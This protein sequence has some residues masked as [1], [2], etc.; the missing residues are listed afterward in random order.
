MSGKT[1][2]VIAHR[3]RSIV[4]AKQI[5]VT[6]RGKLVAQGKHDELLKTCTLYQRLWAANEET[7]NWRLEV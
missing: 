6:D 2:I 1:V 4:G 3:L 7:V 5:L